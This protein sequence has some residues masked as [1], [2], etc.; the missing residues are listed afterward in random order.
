[1]AEIGRQRSGADYLTAVAELQRG[2]R[3]VAR[4]MARYDVLLSPS[5]GEPPACLGSFAS[6]PAFPLGGFL[7]AGSYAAFMTMANITGQPSMSVPLCWNEAGLPVGVAFHG[8]FGDEATLFRLAAQLEEE[9]PWARR[10]PALRGS[11]GAP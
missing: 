8:R 10:V 9:R 2:A 6:P 11:A 1:M 3:E 7:R 4:T 5:L